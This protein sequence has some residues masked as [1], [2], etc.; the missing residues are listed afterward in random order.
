MAESGFLEFLQQIPAVI[1]IVF[2]GSGLALVGVIGAII[3]NRSRRYRA[4]QAKV[5]PSGGGAVYGGA[6]LPDLDV[7]VA[8]TRTPRKGTF[9]VLLSDGGETEAVEVLTVLRDV[10]DGSLIIQVGE[11]A[12]RTPL[13]HADADF[14]RRVQTTLRAL[15]DAA[16]EKPAAV[17]PPSPAPVMTAPP[18][19]AE[20]AMPEPTTAEDVLDDLPLPDFDETLPP[21]TPPPVSPPPPAAVKT[22]VMPGVPLPG[23]L[24][25]FK[26]PENPELPKRGRRVKPSSEPIPEIN[27]ADA[28]ETF[29]QH[30]LVTTQAF[31]GRKIH[32]RSA[33]GG[34]VAIEVDGKYFDTVG[35]VADPDVRT[36]LQTTIEEWQSRQG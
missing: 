26:L 4:L 13:T 16:A 30:K 32:I 1:V 33:L 36:Y 28:I 5:N 9:N 31:P 19:V 17:S 3:A 14:S 25:R 27:I 18:P 11:K 2:C 35:E 6:D 8:P 20:P 22:D 15:S 29:L 10:A 7:L 34:G 24:P 12:Y 23:D 21:V